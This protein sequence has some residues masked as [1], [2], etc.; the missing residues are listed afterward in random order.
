ME[1]FNS[2]VKA[3][4]NMELHDFLRQKVE[5]E[6]LYNYQVAT[7]LNVDKNMVGKLI[8]KSGVR[9]KQGF[10]VRR[11]EESY[12]KGSADT[13]RNMIEGL[14]TSLSDVARY[15]GFSRE[16]A[17]Q[18]YLKFFGR[19]Y[20]EALY[21]K[22]QKIGLFKEEISRNSKKTRNFIAFKERL[23]A[24]GL[25]PR[26]SYDGGERNI[27]VNGFKLAF[28][29]SERPYMS[30]EKLHFRINYRNPGSHKKYDFLICLCRYK[31]K[32]TYYVIPKHAIPKYGICL[33]PEAGLNES[34]YARFREAWDPLLRFNNK[35]GQKHRINKATAP[36][37]GCE[38]YPVRSPHCA[39]ADLCDS[40][41]NLK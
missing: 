28:R 39:L 38:S 31:D 22:R 17:R 5:I 1:Q 11:F 23:L 26:I 32:K 24:L 27:F 7:L 12:G 40:V 33:T 6:G 14:D 18:V 20:S 25:I 30:A 13:F 21:E 9:R 37:V 34:K 2:F 19:P 10:F 8:R 16:Y 29:F 35:I 41:N 36:P 15:F 4:W 3:N